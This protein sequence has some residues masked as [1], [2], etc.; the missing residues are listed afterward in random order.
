[1]NA[2][3]ARMER[4][5]IDPNVASYI[6]PMTWPRWP[7]KFLGMAARIGR[8]FVRM[9]R[10]RYL[11]QMGELLD[12]QAGA[13][14][15]PVTL[16][17]PDPKRW[18]LVDRLVEKFTAGTGTF[19]VVGDDLVSELSATEVA[20]AL[21]R[22]KLD[23]GAYPDDLLALTPAYLSSFPPTATQVVRPSTLDRAKDSRYASAH[24]PNYVMPVLDWKILNLW[25]NWPS[26]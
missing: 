8:P 5:E 7:A 19:S 21:R 3:F 16:D 10:A 9:A 20:I 14:P 18:E 25:P 6:Y 13:W 23:Y 12:V 4:G 17:R 11:R 2:M 24:T 22:F 15:R 26:G 1:M